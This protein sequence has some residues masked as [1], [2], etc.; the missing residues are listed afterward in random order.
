MFFLFTK[1][2]KYDGSCGKLQEIVG[3]NG[4]LSSNGNDGK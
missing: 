4:K 1:N 2:I 3:S